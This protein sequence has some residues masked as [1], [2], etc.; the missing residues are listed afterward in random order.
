MGSGLGV[1][2]SLPDATP[3]AASSAQACLRTSRD[4]EAACIAGA[5]PGACFLGSEGKDGGVREARAVGVARQR[6]LYVVLEA[7]DLR[8]ER[9]GW[10]SRG[11]ASPRATGRTRRWRAPPTEQPGAADVEGTS[12]WGSS[13]AGRTRR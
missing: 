9:H 1:L 4:L 10:C 7:R 12:R 13:P 8:C 3:R 5:I 11:P 2:I 6:R